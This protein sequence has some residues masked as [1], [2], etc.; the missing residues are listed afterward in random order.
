M[1]AQ[2]KSK[3][4]RLTFKIQGETQVALFKGI[5]EVQE[6]FESDSQ[7]GVCGSDNI[8]FQ[9]RTVDG[10]SYYELVCRQPGCHA[11]L[12]YGQHKA[13]GSLFPK[14]YGEDK[15]PLPDRGWRKWN[16]VAR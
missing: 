13:G 8:G 10:N 15:K 11:V 16:G 12:A 4:G 5:A 1:E 14:R 7:C 2:Y 6:V 3:N 9:V